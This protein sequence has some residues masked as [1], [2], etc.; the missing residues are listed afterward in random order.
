MTVGRL[1]G[2]PVRLHPTLL[3]VL[4]LFLVAGH[5]WAMVLAFLSILGH[6]LA[7]VVMA[8]ALD[9]HAATIEL[10]PFGGRADLAGLDSREPA[11]QALVALAG[12]LSSG[13]FA[14]L[15]A[16]LLR[17]MAFPAPVLEFFVAVNAGLALFNLLPATP[18]D[19][20]RILRALRS[21]R[22]G[23]G[24]AAQEVRR[25][26]AAIAI[27]MAA[28]ALILAAF[29]ELAWPLAMVAAFLFWTS[30]RPHSER[31]W[32]IRD[33]A[34]RAAAIARRPVWALSDL[35]VHEDAPISA[36]LDVMHPRELHRV[37]VLG[38]HL[39][40]LGVVWERDILR[41]LQDRGPSLPIGA[42]VGRPPPGPSR[43]N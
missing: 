11:V 6:E 24:P 43:S 19:G 25:I 17:A 41:A 16:L 15:G 7:H 1:F 28:M 38:A 30:R 37:A 33:L 3:I 9:V 13:L 35:A 31:F 42:L 10:W 5:G 18:L 22:L 14:L 39:E 27:A 4:G 36:V 23:Y 12:P 2:V 29:G 26:G 20:G 32:S 21:R 8:E 34:V 40:V